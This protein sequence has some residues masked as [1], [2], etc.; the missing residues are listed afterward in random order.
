MVSSL[1]EAKFSGSGRSGWPRGG[2]GVIPAP[3]VPDTAPHMK[4]GAVKSRRRQ[5]REVR[6]PLATREK[7]SFAAEVTGDAD[8]GIV[9]AGHVQRSAGPLGYSGSARKTLTCFSA[10][11]GLAVASAGPRRG[12][13]PPPGPRLQ[14]GG[15]TAVPPPPLRRQPWGD[16][17]SAV[18][19]ADP[20]S[21]APRHR[22][23]E[24]KLLRTRLALTLS[25]DRS[26]YMR[27]PS[28][29]CMW[30]PGHKPGAPRQRAAWSP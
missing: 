14:G 28:S 23:H 15:D 17:R 25:A 30:P 8:S 5:R 27:R 16:G 22:S 24:E 19:G 21:R 26:P 20:P 7:R 6:A 12:R 3:T 2:H 13:D 11:S 29:R 18:R 4:S 1:S 9:H 10:A